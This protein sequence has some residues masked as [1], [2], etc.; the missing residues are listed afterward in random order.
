MEL[1][2]Q[3]CPR[4][5]QAALAAR[6]DDDLAHEASMSQGNFARVFKDQTG[7]T[8][9]EYVQLMRVYAARRTLEDTNLDIRRI[10]V[11]SGFKRSDSMR[12]AFLSRLGVTAAGYRS[13]FRTSRQ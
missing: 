5:P 9:A 11:A 1:P 3:R 4:Y 6:C 10:A 12:R 13:T 7:T 2:E 8:P